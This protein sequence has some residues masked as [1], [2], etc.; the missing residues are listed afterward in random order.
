MSAAAPPT[1]LTALAPGRW[2]QRVARAVVFALVSVG[3]AVGA[4]RVGGGMTAD[5]RVDATGGLALVLLG[6]A[7]TGRERSGRVIGAVVVASQ[8][9]LHVGFDLTAQPDPTGPSPIMAWARMLWCAD[10]THPTSLAQV[11]AARAGIGMGPLSAG[12]P[13]AHMP[14]TVSAAGLGMLA[15]HLSAAV[16]TAWWLRRGERAAWSLTLSIVASAL[17]TLIVLV[18][19]V[20]RVCSITGR[21]WS[22]ARHSWA[23]ALSGRGPPAG[24]V[25]WSITA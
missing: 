18:P 23:A 25:V 11:N 12:A 19:T 4:H 7:L 24:V 16:A 22:P 5:P 20:E 1:G 21:I 9:V 17:P 6:L 8:A 13:M 2:P 10:G 14:A 15:A 3:L